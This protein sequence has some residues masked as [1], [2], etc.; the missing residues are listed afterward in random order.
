M[1]SEKCPRGL[2]SSPLEAKGWRAR[3]SRDDFPAV[4]TLLLALS[5]WGF[6]DNL[7]WDVG[8]PS[9]RD[10][11]LVVH[12]VFCL[13]WMLVLCVQAHLVRVKSTRSHGPPRRGS[14]FSG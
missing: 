14:S 1:T 10:P 9:N 13:A 5:V 8:Q 12:G 3:L 4:T 11:K 7:L 6:S 2:F